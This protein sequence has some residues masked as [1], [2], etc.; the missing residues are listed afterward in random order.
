MNAALVYRWD[1]KPI[2]LCFEIIEGAYDQDSILLFL[3][4]LRQ[5][6]R[7][8][9]ITL[10]WDGLRAHRTSLIEQYVRRSRG[11]LKIIPLPPYAPEMNPTEYLWANIKGGELANAVP[12]GIR[13][14]CKLAVKGVRRAE[15]R[16]LL[17]GF[18]RAAGLFF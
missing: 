5:E 18:V 12:P 6:F 14:L 15:R 9:P 10:V 3:R 7:G 11:R 2:R 1:G 17:K 4:R 13:D 16:Q 8:R